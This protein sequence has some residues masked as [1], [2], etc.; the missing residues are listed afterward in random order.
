MICCLDESLLANRLR[1]DS[2]VRYSECG[3]SDVERFKAI[4]ESEDRAWWN[5]FYDLLDPFVD[6]VDLQDHRPAIFNDHILTKSVQ[7][8]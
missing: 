3:H 5:G 8:R 7:N 1:F 4:E 2:L 6:Y